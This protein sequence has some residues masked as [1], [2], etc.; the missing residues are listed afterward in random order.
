MTDDQRP[1]FRNRSYPLSAQIEPFV[2]DAWWRTELFQTRERSHA[3]ENA[4]STCY[5]DW[6]LSEA[7]TDAF[8]ARLRRRRIGDM[9]LVECSCGPCSGRREKSVIRHDDDPYLGLQV[10]LDGTERFHTQEGNTALAAGDCIIWSTTEP[11]EF[12]IPD[13]LRKST[14]L[15]RHSLVRERLTPRCRIK[16][17]KLDTRQ[18]I[19]AILRSHLLALTSQFDCLELVDQD[20]VK[21]STVELLTAA[22]VDRCEGDRR[23]DPFR[24]RL[25]ERIMKFILDNLEDS[26]LDLARIA[27]AHR[28]SVRYLHLLFKPLGRTVSSWIREQRLL[29]CRDALVSRKSKDLQVTEIA[30]QWGFSDPAHFSR[31]F[32]KRFGESPSSAR[33][34]L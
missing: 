30:Y 10:V 9:T 18:G 8:S 4:L 28:I 23:W 32:R 27:A 34:R 14:L 19:G 21:W 33:R 22:I 11:L 20:A 1:S 2:S 3:W 6:Q 7:L 5:R 17:F 13:H 24:G 25:L 31:V 26:E 29:R 15:I 12:G 16:S